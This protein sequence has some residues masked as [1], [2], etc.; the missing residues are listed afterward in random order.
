MKYAL[1]IP[2]GAADLPIEEL[3]GRTVLEAADIPNLDRLARAGRVGTTA[4]VP[5]G[6]T[7]GSDVA[8]MSVLGYDPSADYTGRAPLEAAAMGIKT[9]PDQIVFRCNLVTILD[10]VMADFSAGHIQTDEAKTLITHL[11]DHLGDETIRFYPGLS[12]RHLMVTGLAERFVGLQTTPPHDIIGRPISDHLPRGK[13]SD[14]LNR[15]MAR[16][17]QLLADHELNQARKD[18]AERPASGIWLWGQGQTPTLEPFR[19]IYGLSGAVVTAVDLVR[20]LARLIDCEIINVDGATGYIDTN[21]AGKAQAACHAMDR[22]DLVVVHVEA[23]D[24]AGHSGDVEAKKT[25]VERIDGKIIAPVVRKLEGFD[26][27]RILVLPDHPTP[28][29]VRSHTSQPVPFVVAGSDISE[30]G[31]DA[32]DER[33]ARDTGLKIAP[34]WRLMEFFLQG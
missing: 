32:F 14:W 1:I 11:N 9:S 21:Y 30:S 4:N 3:G 10:G 15:L 18:R 19:S 17:G 16:A 12:Y 13:G 25:A 24:E 2:D 26:D 5:D 28:I 31:P 23:P 8:I 20:G 22:V 27:W 7:P 29:A 33:H 34:G 6:M